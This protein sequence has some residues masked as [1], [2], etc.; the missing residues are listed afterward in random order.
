MVEMDTLA[1][2]A[3][4]DVVVPRRGCLNRKRRGRER[5]EEGV[6][7]LTERIVRNGGRE[8]DAFALLW[9]WMMGKSN[10]RCNPI[11]FA[12]CDDKPA[13]P[14]NLAQN[15]HESGTKPAP[16]IP[17][18]LIYLFFMLISQEW[19][20]LQFSRFSLPRR[21][22]FQYPQCSIPCLSCLSFHPFNLLSL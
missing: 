15:S 5:R 18:I 20:T 4:C 10:Q 2:P 11:V 17:V 12:N 1:A 16:E 3:R 14:C 19:V 8:R 6:D 22:V 21:R 7:R 13:S 9:A